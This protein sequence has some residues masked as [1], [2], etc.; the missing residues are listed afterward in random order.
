MTETAVNTCAC[1]SPLFERLAPLT[2]SWLEINGYRVSAQLRTRITAGA[3]WLC[4]HTHLARV[5]FK[6]R[7]A[8]AWLAAQGVALPDTPNRWLCDTSGATIARLGIEDFLIADEAE[9]TS[10]LPQNLAA[11]WHAASTAGGFLVPRQ[12]GLAAIALGGVSAPQLLAHLCA[13]DLRP[14]AFAS[15]A[16]AQTQLALSSV[17]IMRSSSTAAAS[18]RLFVDTSLALYLWDVLNDVAAT[19]GGGALGSTQLSCA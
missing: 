12:H 1:R 5:G 19:L 4:D 11:R 18:Y 15:D 8:A 14:Q 9:Q 16:I 13:V 3:P 17:V 10:G 7:G 2:S 6:G